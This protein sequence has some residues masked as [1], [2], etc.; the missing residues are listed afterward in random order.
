MIDLLLSDLQVANTF[1]TEAVIV[2]ESSE[3]NPRARK[4]S[5]HQPPF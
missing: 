4:N 2:A 1:L 3:R 5:F